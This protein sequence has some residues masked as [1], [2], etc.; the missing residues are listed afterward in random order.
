MHGY[1][2]DCGVRLVA[3]D[4]EGDAR[5]ER[6]P[7]AYVGLVM[8]E[9]QDTIARGDGTMLRTMEKRLALLQHRE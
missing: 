3:Y 6:E 9:G 4:L 5:E 1:G 7:S 8:A 2:K